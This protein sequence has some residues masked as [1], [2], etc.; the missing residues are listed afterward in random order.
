M[1]VAAPRARQSAASIG[2]FESRSC[3]GPGR[4]EAG[5]SSLPVT[6]IVTRGRSVDLDGLRSGERGQ[7]DVGR[8]Q[9]PSAGEQQGPRFDALAAAAQVLARS[10]RRD[11]ATTVPLSRRTFSTGTIASVPV[12]IG[13]PVMTR[14][15]SP[16][17]SGAGGASP[18]ATRPGRSA[19][20]APPAACGPTRTA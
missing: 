3:P 15:A 6:A 13:A 8:A 17:S 10:R 14:T 4:C 19:S 16:G 5:T 20:A 1:A 2:P 11:A 9:P 12:G 7:R 18:A